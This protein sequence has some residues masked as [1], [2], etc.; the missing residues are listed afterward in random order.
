MAS[1]AREREARELIQ[2]SVDEIDTALR[3]VNR[4]NTLFQHSQYAIL[5]E[6]RANLDR[7]KA[8][9]REL[10]GYIQ[11]LHTQDVIGYGIWYSD[12]ISS[13]PAS[14]RFNVATYYKTAD[15][16]KRVASRL[17]KENRNLTFMVYPYNGNYG[18]AGKAVFL[19]LSD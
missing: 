17:A 16:A 10:T 9:M 2:K 12:H 4:L 3:S 14:G 18:I 5:S 8:K 19:S 1:G 6:A 11:Y 7:A 15:E 13:Y